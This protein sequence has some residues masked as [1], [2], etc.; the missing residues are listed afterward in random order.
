MQVISAASCRCRP[1]ST[2]PSAS[3]FASS[4]SS[5]SA[6]AGD[7]V[8]R[9]AQRVVEFAEVGVPRHPAPVALRV[10]AARACGRSCRAR[11]P[12]SISPAIAREAGDSARGG[13]RVAAPP[14]EGG[15]IDRE[16]RTLRRHGMAAALLRSRQPMISAAT[17]RNASAEAPAAGTTSTD[18]IMPCLRLDRRPAAG[19][20]GQVRP[21][22]LGGGGSRCGRPSARFRIAR[23]AAGEHRVDRLRRGGVARHA[24]VVAGGADRGD[25]EHAD[26][27]FELQLL[28]DEV[29]VAA[30][31]CAPRPRLPAARPRS[32]RRRRRRTGTSACRARCLRRRRPTRRPCSPPCS[33]PPA[34]PRW[35]SRRRRR[36]PA[37]RPAAACRPPGSLTLLESVEDRQRPHSGSRAHGQAASAA[38]FLPEAEAPAARRALE[39]CSPIER[40]SCG[41][42]GDVAGREHAA[43][44]F[45]QLLDPRHLDHRRP[46]AEKASRSGTPMLP[47][48]TGPMLSPMP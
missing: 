23:A 15:G 33:G 41:S 5:A 13:L 43:P 38:A 17:S 27:Q 29:A 6:V 21:R 32:R 11:S 9:H 37:S 22:V 2:T 19:E 4:A 45:G 14:G 30:M 46:M 3:A 28:G 26:P 34:A 8:D 39:R 40:Q 42:N 12:T 1:Y 25:R 10:E 47:Y 18:R 24:H 44:T 7:A 48:I 36:R 20:P 35:I 31:A 16:L